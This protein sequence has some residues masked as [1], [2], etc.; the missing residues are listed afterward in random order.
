MKGFSDFKRIAVVC[1]PGEDELKRRIA[2][3]EEKGNAFTVKEST[4]NNLR[5]KYSPP[6]NQK[7]KPTKKK[8][9]YNK[10][11]YDIV[12]LYNNCTTSSPSAMQ[13]CITEK[14]EKNL[15]IYLICIM[16]IM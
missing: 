14:K 15:Y 1:I 11:L 3:K 16:F 4:I 9:K 13:I 12:S 10:L 6:Q 7:K 8:E 5:G 2:E